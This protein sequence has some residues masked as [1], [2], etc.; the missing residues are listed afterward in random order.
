MTDT[1]PTTTVRVA[2]GRR[3]YDIRIG[4][5]LMAHAAGHLAPVL[6]RSPTRIVTD[7]NLAAAWLPRL[8]AALDGAGIVH[9]TKI[10]P[11]GEQTKS[12]GQVATLT[13]WLLEQG[14]DRETVLIALG[15]GVIGDLCGFVA[16]ITLRGIP[17]VQIP[18]TLL[19]QVDSSVGGKTGIDTAQGKNL[20]GAFH[21]PRLVLIDTQTLDTLPV[22][23][24]RAGYAE[25]I[26]YGM[27]NDPDFFGWCEN[28][29]E[30]LLRGDPAA[31]RY[32]IETACRAKAAIVGED[33]RESGRR[34][35]LNLGHTFAHAFETEAGYGDTLLH[36]EAVA[37]GCL[38]ALRLS[39][40]L[41]LCAAAD[42]DRV[43]AHLNAVGL[44]TSLGPIMATPW[45][46]QA[47]LR[48]MKKDKKAIG[49]GLTFVLL[50][51][52]GD[53]FISRDVDA[54]TVRGFLSDILTGGE[55]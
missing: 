25:T 49:G 55:I 36:G 51:A 4:D 18:T 10:L 22:R 7:E 35:V 34:A 37:I 44:P 2:L 17:F 13:D 11:A 41:G 16:A 42:V 38:C 21:Q 54:E 23:Q 52:L 19:A 48:H 32:A 8:Q 47:I 6:G 45:S 12:L 50:R 53:A 39:Q 3:S 46:A 31:R 14:V 30:K 26:K 5:G 1:V 27:I 43:R 9:A 40:Q 33:E 28:N 24:V 15:G 29:A 20:I